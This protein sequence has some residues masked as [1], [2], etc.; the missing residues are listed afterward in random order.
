MGTARAAFREAARRAGDVPEQ[1]AANATAGRAIAELKRIRVAVARGA[2]ASQITSML[3]QGKHSMDLLRSQI[4]GIRN[5]AMNMML[6]QRAAVD[7]MET[8]IDVVTIVGAGAR[9]AG[10]AGRGRVVRVRHFPPGGG[11]RGER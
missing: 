2:P 4:A 10:R 7:R 6:S 9:L 8:G 3:T 5:R 11:G 1:R